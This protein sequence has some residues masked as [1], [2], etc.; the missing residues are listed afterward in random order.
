MASEEAKTKSKGGCRFPT[1][2]TM[3]LSLCMICFLPPASGFFLRS[4]RISK[5]NAI[6]KEN[7]LKTIP[8]DIPPTATNLDLSKNLIENIQASN[9]TNLPVLSSLDLFH[10]HIAQIDS[11]AFAGLIS[12]RCL[13]LNHNKLTHL[14]DRVFNGLRNLTELR[15]NTNGIKVVSPTAFQSLTRLKYLDISHNKLETI[16][17]LRL[18]LQ[19]MPQLHKLVVKG[20]SLKSFHS[21]ELTNRSLSLATLDLSGNPLNDFRITA[22]I[23]PNLTCFTIGDPLSKAPMIW[24]VGDKTFLKQV[25]NLDISGL[26]MALADTDALLQAVN[27]S[28]KSLSMNSMKLNLRE[29]INISC[30]I[31]TMSTLEL[32]SNNL[33]F[34]SSDFL[35]LCINVA[36]LHLEK[37]VVNKIQEDAFSSLGRLRTLSLSH[38]RLSSVPNATKNLQSLS[39]LD[40]SYNRIKTVGCQDFHNLT[41]LVELNLQNNSISALKDCL[42]NNLVRLQVLA[43]QFNQIKHLKG[44]FKTH[45]PKLQIMHLNGN[46]LTALLPGEFGG[47]ESLLNLSLHGNEIAKLFNESFVGLT[48]LLKLDLTSNQITRQ[49]LDTGAFNAL[50]NL[51]RLDLSINHIKYDDSMALRETPFGTLSSLEEL[52]IPSQHYRLKSHLPVNFLQGLTNLLR[53]SARNIQVIYLD[54]NT[55]KYTP[56]LEKLDISSNDL[57][58]LSAELFSP[59]QTLKSLYISRTQIRSLDFLIDANLTKLEFLQARLNQYSVITEHVMNSLPFLQYVDFENNSFSCDC[60]NAWFLNWTITI[61]QTQVANAYNFLCNYPDDFKDK[62]LLDFAIT[63]CSQ[64][65][66]FICFVSTTSMILFVMVASFSYHFMRWQLYSAYYLFLSWLFDTKQKNKQAPCQYDAFISYNYHDEPWVIGELLPKLEG[67]QGWRLCLHHRD[68]EPGKPVIDNITDA[69]YSSRKTICVISRRYLES[70]WCSREVQTASFR[71]FDEQEDV[72]ILV[73]LEDIPTYL[74]SPYHRMRKLLKKQTYLSWPRAA[75]QPEVFWEKLRKALQTGN[76][77]CEDNLLLNVTQTQ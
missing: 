23:F 70:E 64:D 28:L 16:A 13:D 59:L 55:F 76:D 39:K 77:P 60:D 5:T 49:G 41:K 56:R 54:K 15:L 35:K 9:V 37:N 45:L 61:K 7:N 51:L 32:Q 47:L 58:T 17:S 67:E 68:F 74:L 53:F 4:C 57:G 3:F 36:E 30:S 18:V 46:K 1:I 40:L 29:L 34:I 14:G 10:N 24:D 38:N 33:K 62:K 26:N 73:F 71:L 21:W 43:L 22:D 65:N 69:I 75:D 12:L 27:S 52:L 8:Q 50:T 11:D 44:A 72:L 66:G 19:H 6:C 2:T 31:P 42:F 25:S 20:N 48:N 63:S